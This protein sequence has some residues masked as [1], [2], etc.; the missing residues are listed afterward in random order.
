MEA[1]GDAEEVPVSVRVL[2]VVAER[3]HVAV[4]V[5]VADL[6]ALDV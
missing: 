1:V 3:V 2:L 4:R 6:V 5:G